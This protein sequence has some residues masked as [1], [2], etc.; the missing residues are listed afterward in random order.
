MCA[1]ILVFSN[2]VAAVLLAWLVGMT[3][4][5]VGHFFFEPREY[6]TVNH[7]THE[8]KEDVKLGY[9]LRRKV[10]LMAVWAVSPLAALFRSRPC[11]ASS[12]RTP[13]SPPS[14]IMSH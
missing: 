7:A 10:V 8:H 5:Q 9:N 6:D 2:P 3:S 11:S 4:R 13:T 1:Y 14:C 12:S